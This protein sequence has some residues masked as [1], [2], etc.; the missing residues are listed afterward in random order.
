MCIAMIYM[1]SKCILCYFVCL[2]GP[3]VQSLQIQIT[4]A[5]QILLQIHCTESEIIAPC[6]LLNIDYIE[7]ISNKL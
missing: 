2:T 7:N 4:V 5:K 6:I 1:A 3:V